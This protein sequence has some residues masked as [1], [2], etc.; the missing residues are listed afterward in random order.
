[1]YTKGVACAQHLKQGCG[2]VRGAEDEIA[3][4]EWE[5]A[6]VAGTGDGVWCSLLSAFC[7]GSHLKS[8][9]RMTVFE[10]HGVR[11]GCGDAGATTACARTRLR[12]S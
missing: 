2:L 10:C 6:A 3:L 11:A 1:V 12:S 4:E 9:P 7:Y 8:A 5:G